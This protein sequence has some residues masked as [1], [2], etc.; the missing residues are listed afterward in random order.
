MLKGIMILTLIVLIAGFNVAW[1]IRHANELE[2]YSLSLEEALTIIENLLNDESVVEN[3]A[4][5]E[6]L[7]EL[8]ES[9]VRGDLESISRNLDN[10]S[11]VLDD[12]VS[13]GSYE[14]LSLNAKS[15][16]PYITSWSINTEHDDIQIIVDVNEY[17]RLLK[18][19]S[20]SIE[21]MDVQS[22]SRTLM[23][24][25]RLLEAYP[26]IAQSFKEA[27]ELLKN[28]YYE[29]AQTRYTEGLSKLYAK[30]PQILD[31]ESVDTSRLIELLKLLPSYIGSEGP[32]RSELNLVPEARDEKVA[33]INP[34]IVKTS[35]FNIKPLPYQHPKLN[36]NDY[37]PILIGFFIIIVIA[38]SLTRVRA[39]LKS[40]SEGVILAYK[41]SRVAKFMSRKSFDQPLIVEAYK[42]ALNY[43]KS[44]GY[45][46]EP[47]ETPRE[48]LMK[49]KGSPFYDGMKI[50]T[51]LYEKAAYGSRKLEATDYKVAR[52]SLAD[53]VRCKR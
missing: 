2:S 14:S 27:S 36:Y 20:S 15:L 25:S 48:F 4:L 41:R 45:I 51:T 9:M 40:V 38:A 39:T 26:E 49:L 43:L 17:T 42:E 10:L 47:Y 37:I 30:L 33:A 44:I 34:Y 8:K 7:E 29:E 11:V 19:L 50:L 1:A 16:L 3:S 31:D 13:T 46:K 22:T 23:E 6:V 53:I 12:L 24:L 5:H 35:I 52:K 32:V 18:L 28:G 21:V